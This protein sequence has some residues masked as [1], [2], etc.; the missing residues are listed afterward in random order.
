MYMY[1]MLHLQY[2]AWPETITDMTHRLKKMY[3]WALIAGNVGLQPPH[4]V[5]VAQQTM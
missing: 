4:V 1:L 3:R 2:D 5:T